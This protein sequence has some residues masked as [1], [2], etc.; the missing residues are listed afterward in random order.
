MISLGKIKIS[1]GKAEKI[2]KKSWKN[3][4]FGCFFAENCEI[5]WVFPR[6]TISKKPKA[7]RDQ[8]GGHGDPLRNHRAEA[9]EARH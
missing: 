1:H 7:I 8:A 2:L 4:R 9:E 3:L 5:H 6:K